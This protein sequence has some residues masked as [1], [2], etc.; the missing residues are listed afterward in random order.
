MI[1][2]AH[3]PLRSSFST[4]HQHSSSA[5]TG[6]MAASDDENELQRAIAL[7]LQ[8]AATNSAPEESSYDRDLRLAMALSLEGVSNGDAVHSVSQDSGNFASQS[9][10]SNASESQHK[11]QLQI[12][13]S[14]AQTTEPPA[15]VS[16]ATL[17]RKAM[18]EA[19]LAR[20]GKRKRRTSPD[21]PSKQIAKQAEAAASNEI[22]YPKGAIK[23]TWAYKYPRTDD[24]SLDEVL[25][26]ATLNIAVFSSFQWDS[27][28]IFHKVDPKNTKQMWIIGANTD[29]MRQRILQ[30]LAECDNPNVKPHFPPMRATTTMHSK[31][32][33]L[34][35]GTH[36]RI[37]VPTAN[38]M[39]VEWGETGK[40]PKSVGSWQP[41]V[42]ENTVFLI[43]LPRRPDRKIAEELETA[44]G[45]SLKGFLEAQEISQNVI[46]G[47]R[48]FDFSETKRLAF[49]HSM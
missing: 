14:V 2:R 7:S 35:H 33:L 8:D 26:A 6:Q 39:Q 5:N 18:E 4:A 45:Q 17:D 43:D 23:R 36:L 42:L 27:K 37:V 10:V 24:I 9:A 31:L 28:W 21:R 48:K 20:L 38:L 25:Q 15:G 16:F 19:R 22:Q 46:E 47:L 3:C 49:V 44:F 1:A 34:F 13:A 29:A 41:A 30:E 11:A 12:I 40:D 32:M